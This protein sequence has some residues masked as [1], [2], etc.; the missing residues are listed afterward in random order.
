M[1][2]FRS[3]ELE[4]IPKVY[5]Y[6]DEK[7]RIFYQPHLYGIYA[8][9]RWFMK[10]M[11]K[12]RECVTRDPEKA[13]LFCLPYSAR[14]LEMGPYT[15]TMHTELTRHT[16]KAQ[17]NADVSEAIFVANKDVS[18]PE[19]ATKTPRRPLK[20]VGGGIRVSQRP[21]LAFFAG[22]MHGW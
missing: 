20:N 18:Q 17:C 22:N 15:L 7:K 10:F 1:I 19:T 16:M 8:P 13:H 14:Q 5:I 9:E 2:H 4:L 21:I 11:E 3:Y 12:I 6:P